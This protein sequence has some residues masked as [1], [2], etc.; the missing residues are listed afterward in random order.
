METNLVTFPAKCL[1]WFMPVIARNCRNLSTV[2]LLLQLTVLLAGVKRTAGWI[3]F[4]LSWALIWVTLSSL[5]T[6]KVYTLLKILAPFCI[7]LKPT[8]PCSVV[9]FFW[10]RQADQRAGWIYR[11]L[12]SEI[13]C[14]YEIMVLHH[15]QPEQSIADTR[16]E[17]TILEG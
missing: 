5:A 11:I 2:Q 12:G 3:M 15:E 1:W 10:R 13:A 9:L 16:Q 6:S 4:L 17:A 8:F 7:A 14:Q